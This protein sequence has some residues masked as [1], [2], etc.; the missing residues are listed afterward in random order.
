[1]VH[2]RVLS[3]GEAWETAALVGDNDIFAVTALVEAVAVLQE[4]GYVPH[5]PLAF[6]VLEDKA[7]RRDR[8]FNVLR[9]EDFGALLEQLYRGYI[10]AGLPALP[11]VPADI[12]GWFA[13]QFE[14]TIP[15]RY[16]ALGEALA[17][18][19][20]RIL[21]LPITDIFTTEFVPLAPVARGV[22]VPTQFAVDRLVLDGKGDLILDHAEGAIIPLAL[23][24]ELRSALGSGG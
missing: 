4:T 21:R 14:L 3:R 6:E 8:A 19:L 18:D 15:V 10:A 20:G 9:S 17:T 2:D 12:F 11:L 24:A 7:K 5:Q 13:V 22:R 16:P 23:V 1:V